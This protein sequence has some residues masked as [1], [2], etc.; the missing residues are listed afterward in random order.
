MEHVVGGAQDYAGA[1]E[2]RGSQPLF[3]LVGQY[4]VEDRSQIT[5][6]TT[7]IVDEI[8]SWCWI[9]I[10]TRLNARVKSIDDELSL[11]SG[12]ALGEGFAGIFTAQVDHGRAATAECSS[13]G[14]RKIGQ[15]LIVGD[16]WAI[17]IGQVVAA[18]A[19]PGDPFEKVV[20]PAFLQFF[21]EGEEAVD[22]VPGVVAWSRW[23]CASEFE[24]V[25]GG[26]A[27]ARLAGGL[28][29]GDLRREGQHI[30]S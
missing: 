29:T 22:G 5:H 10:A 6:T 2:R 3:Q 21:S 23:A 28:R 8:V 19:G 25:S 12:R 13:Q 11:G 30:T 9:A 20:T 15:D 17:G 1:G 14:H 16:V 26:V 4:A 18:P 7:E 24:S 27:N